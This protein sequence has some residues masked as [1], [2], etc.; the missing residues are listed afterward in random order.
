MVHNK[1]QELQKCNISEKDVDHKIFEER[2]VLGD[3]YSY[4]SAY[5][6]I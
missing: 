2:Y 1:E 6:E 4:V 5:S 3:T